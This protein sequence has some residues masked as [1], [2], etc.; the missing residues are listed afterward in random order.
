M[1]IL[2]RVGERNDAE[3]VQSWDELGQSSGIWG[4]AAQ[5]TKFSFAWCFYVRKYWFGLVFFF[6]DRHSC[7]PLNHWLSTPSAINFLE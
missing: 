6:P 7:G 4:D 1:T 3:R 5:E 2:L